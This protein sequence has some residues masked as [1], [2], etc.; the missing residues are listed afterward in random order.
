MYRFKVVVAM[1]VVFAPSSNALAQATG[2]SETVLLRCDPGSRIDG[3]DGD[4]RYVIA[5]YGPTYNDCEIRLSAGKHVVKACYELTGP[6]AIPETFTC[7]QKRDLEFDASPGNVY[8][9]RLKITPSRVW[10]AWIEDV[11]AKES[12][13]PASP[14]INKARKDLPKDQ[15]KS[16]ILVR[17]SER[18][19]P[20]FLKGQVQHLWFRMKDLR[21]ALSAPSKMRSEKDGY[22]TDKVSNGDSLAIYYM[23][24]Q[25]GS[26]FSRTFD[27]VCD[28]EL[29]VYEDLPGGKVLYLGDYRFERAPDGGRRF[30]VTHD[31]EAARNFLRANHPELVDKLV[32]ADSRM[33]RTPEICG[34]RSGKLR[35][36]TAP[37]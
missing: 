32:V 13:V 5:S 16:T 23:F 3:I 20:A 31:V 27:Y 7:D 33:L 18:D 12:D 2:G 9:L 30:T 26:A 25:D 29:P 4:G 21:Q 15:R 14:V 1:L 35:I 10:N 37:Q 28:T 36:A 6:G 24:H 34:I 17:A 22:F 11:T 19:E 8:R